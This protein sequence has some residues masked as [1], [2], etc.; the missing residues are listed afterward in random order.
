MQVELKP[1]GAS[2]AVTEA[3]KHEYVSLLIDGKMMKMTRAQ[4]RVIKEGEAVLLL[5]S[6]LLIKLDK[7]Q[8]D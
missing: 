4:H 6:L 2:I 1:H 8:A 7:T 3:S 5:M